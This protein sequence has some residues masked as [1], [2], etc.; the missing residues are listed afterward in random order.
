ML[1]VYITNKGAKEK[2]KVSG[3]WKKIN[4]KLYSNKQTGKYSKAMCTPMLNIA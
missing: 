3:K 1:I 2:G 4:I